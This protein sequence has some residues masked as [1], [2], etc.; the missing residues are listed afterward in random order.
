MVPILSNLPPN[1]APVIQPKYSSRMV[2]DSLKHRF[3]ECELEYELEINMRFTMDL[4]DA[5]DAYFHK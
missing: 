5:L 1:V 2:R 4:R 3:S